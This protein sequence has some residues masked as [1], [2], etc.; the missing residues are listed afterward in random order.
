MELEKEIVSGGT[1]SVLTGGSVNM[2]L[3]HGGG[4]ERW[5]FMREVC[6]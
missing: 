2:K 4:V 6:R 3:S 5:G 1:E